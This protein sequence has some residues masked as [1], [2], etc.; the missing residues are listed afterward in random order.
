[1]GTISVMGLIIITLII[2]I[3]ARKANKQKKALALIALAT[4][5][6]QIN[7][8][9]TKADIITNGYIAKYD[10]D[11]GEKQKIC[12]IQDNTL[13]H[14]NSKTVKVTNV[15][16]LIMDRQIDSFVVPLHE[17]LNREATQNITCYGTTS[18][19]VKHP[20]KH[21]GNE[22]LLFIIFKRLKDETS[23]S[24]I[25]NIRDEKQN[26]QGRIQILNKHVVMAI[27]KQRQGTLALQWNN[28]DMTSIGLPYEIILS[29]TKPTAS[30]SYQL[31]H[32]WFSLGKPMNK[33]SQ[34]VALSSGT[35]VLT[36]D[37]MY[38]KKSFHNER[39]IYKRIPSNHVYQQDD[40][41]WCNSTAT[42]QMLRKTLDW[43]S[44]QVFTIRM[45]TR[46]VDV[47][48]TRESGIHKE[49]GIPDLTQIYNI[50]K[51]WI[52][53]KCDNLNKGSK[54][55]QAGRC[56]QDITGTTTETYDKQ[57]NKVYYNPTDPSQSSIDLTKG[58]L[59]GNLKVKACVVT[60][61]NNAKLDE[62]LRKE[63]IVNLTSGKHF[64]IHKDNMIY[65]TK[66]SDYGYFSY[67]MMN[68]G[69]AKD[70]S[71]Q[72]VAF[73][74]YRNPE[75]V[76]HTIF[77]FPTVF[78]NSCN[79]TGEQ[80]I[81]KCIHKVRFL[82]QQRGAPHGLHARAIYKYQSVYEEGSNRLSIPFAS[83]VIVDLEKDWEEEMLLFIDTK[84]E[85]N[86]TVEGNIFS[87]VTRRVLKKAWPYKINDTIT[88][89]TVGLVHALKALNK[90]PPYVVLT[91]NKAGNYVV[92][93]NISINHLMIVNHTN[94]TDTQ[95]PGW[96][97]AYR[98]TVRLLIIQTGGVYVAICER[99]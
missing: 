61:F 13:E 85:T 76:N 6:G 70:P 10:F 14:L 63:A 83:P 31:H 9:A 21:N 43:K 86:F 81:D 36:W 97:V 23:A 46:K 24:I 62:G 42:K 73:Y 54:H 72:K 51:Q 84:K 64:L 18:T 68:F 35:N 66:S 16:Y 91:R 50:N 34:Y 52:S 8:P 89:I 58:I 78:K 45:A 26:A 71:W 88:V 33:I 57:G 92:Q 39:E 29:V 55:S 56:C 75:T 47:L 25:I 49:K 4:I 2:G 94:V 38:L 90:I 67:P 79:K 15:T 53:G 12:Q 22:T 60:K 27:P 82:E 11:I 44:A 99:V 3:A 96:I 87:E 17:S 69:S 7:L 77:Y 30:D 28:Q 20:I 19:Y 37:D 1:M 59:T 32:K 48:L 5:G 74:C 98:R 65:A 41:Y 80:L 95:R 93:P 40:L